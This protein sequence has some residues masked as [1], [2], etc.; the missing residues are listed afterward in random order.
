MLPELL[1]Q[2]L[3]LKSNIEP[4][5]NEIETLVNN[6]NMNAAEI[7]VRMKFLEEVFEAARQKL[8]DTVRAEVELFGKSDTLKIQ[9][10]KIEPVE[11]SV[12]YDYSND[13]TWSE[14]NSRCEVVNDERKEREKFLK[15]LTKKVITVNEE[16]GETSEV[17]PPIRTSKSSFKITLG[18]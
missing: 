10:A 18:K 8:H 2:N 15:T 1:K 3:P 7:L 5:V 6:G 14:I 13:A 4:M 12:K 11:T 16:T 9:G 17:L